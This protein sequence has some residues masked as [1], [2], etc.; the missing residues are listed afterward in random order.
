MANNKKN[1]LYEDFGLRLQDLRKDSVRPM[2]Q[3]R[4]GWL[5]G[6]SRT[7]ITNIE[8]GRQQVSLHQL[9]RIADAL[10]IAPDLLLPTRSAPTPPELSSKLPAGTEPG[11]A[12]WIDTLEVR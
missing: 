6:L 8:K 1:R 2:T 11:I 3:A 5:V 10:D 4:L 7:S 12:T 9:Y